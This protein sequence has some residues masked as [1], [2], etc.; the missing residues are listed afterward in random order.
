MILAF[1]IVALAGTQ[2]YAQYGFARLGVGYGMGANGDVLGVSTT[3]DAV[4]DVT[5]QKNIYGSTGP[6]LHIGAAGGYMFN[7]HVGFELG[8]EYLYGSKVKVEEFTSPK[9]EYYTEAYTRQFRVIPSLVVQGGGDISPYARFGIVLPVAGQSHGDR[10]ADDVAIVSSLIPSLLPTA[11]EFEVE[12]TIKGKFA[13]GFRAAAG[14]SYK[15]SD[16]L[17][18]FGEVFYTGLRVQR[19]TLEVT[20]ANVNDANGEND[21]IGLLTLGGASQFIEY[22][23]EIN[24]AEEAAYITEAGTVMLTLPDGTMLPASAVGTSADTP[25]RALREDGNFNAFGLTIGVRATFGR[26]SGDE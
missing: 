14:V 24:A 12:S 1:A 22:V 25:T 16:K 17:D 21:V 20:R 18:L 2:A 11:T 23:D 26:D 9:G 19:N 6:G 4:Y 3:L 5:D 13:V 10:Y 15:L 8:L 7:D